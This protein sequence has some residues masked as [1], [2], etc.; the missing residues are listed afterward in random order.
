MEIHEITIEDKNS[1]FNSADE[2]YT[3]ETKCTLNMLDVIDLINV[4]YT[5]GRYTIKHHPVKIGQSFGPSWATKWFALKCSFPIGY[6]VKDGRRLALK[7]D[8]SSEAMVYDA[9][10]KAL[11]A[12]TGGGGNDRRD[13]CLLSTDVFNQTDC[14]C[15]DTL[16]IEMAC[17]EMFGNGNGGMIMAPNPNRQFQLQM[18]EMVE[19]NWNAQQLLWDMQLLLD[20]ATKSTSPETNPYCSAAL[21]VATTIMDN[22]DLQSDKSVEFFHSMTSNFLGLQQKQPFTH[23]SAPS[24]LCS[25]YALGH[26]HIDTAWLWPYKETRR[27]IARSW[28]SQLKLLEE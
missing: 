12:F 25:L 27:K 16:Y 6:I 5:P 15:P 1:G 23:A 20:L 9:T 11:Q 26:C 7:W 19:I 14:T 8:S 4:K 28:A 2:V 21:D 18:A 17:N 22:I 3:T 13:T 10:G 24:N